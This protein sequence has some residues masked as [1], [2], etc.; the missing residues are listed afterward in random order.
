LDGSDRT[1]LTRVADRFRS[2]K[3][4]LSSMWTQGRA[5]ST[6]GRHWMVLL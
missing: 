2:R 3:S 6:K 1:A 4:S 5:V